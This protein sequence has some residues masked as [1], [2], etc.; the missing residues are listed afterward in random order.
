MEESFLALAAMA[1]SGVEYGRLFLASDV[2]ARLAPFFHVASW[3]YLAVTFLSSIINAYTSTARER[4]PSINGFLQ[5]NTWMGENT[6]P[7][8]TAITSPMG[9]GDKNG[10]MSPSS[11]GPFARRAAPEPNKRAL[12]V[13]GWSTGWTRAL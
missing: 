6:N 13:G 7:I 5:Q 2:Q 1:S 11:G 4:G 3:V 8:P 9:G 12:Y 10:I